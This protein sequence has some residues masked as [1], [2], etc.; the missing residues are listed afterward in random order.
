MCPDID[1]DDEAHARPSCR[2]RDPDRRS[3]ACWAGARDAPG[4]PHRRRRWNE[5]PGRRR[6]KVARRPPWCAARDSSRFRTQ[7]V[8]VRLA[9]VAA[10]ETARAIAHAV[11]G[12][13]RNAR[14]PRSRSRVELRARAAAMLSGAAGVGPQLV[15]DEVQRKARFGDL[16]A[17]E[18]DAAAECHSPALGQPSPAGEAPPPGRAWKRCQ[19]NLRRVRRSVPA[20]A[21][22]KRRTH[23]AMARSGQASASAVTIASTI[24]FAQWL[25]QSVTGAPS[26]TNTTVPGLG[27]HAAGGGT[28]HRSS[29][30]RHR[31]DR[32]APSRRPTACWHARSSRSWCSADPTPSGR[33]SGPIRD[34][35]TRARIT[36]SSRPCPSSSSVAWPFVGPS[37][38]GRDDRAGAPLGGVEHGV[39]RGEEARRA[40]LGRAAL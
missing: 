39:D 2:R 40:E 20:M 28:R 16:D 18:L 30:Y 29:G 38:P 19:M 17:A 4:H 31:S 15:S 3:A 27:E 23:P 8:A 33:P 26:F 9:V 6:A 1:A 7:H 36:M 21:M 34:L 35:V 14:T 12:G 5:R 24:S 37:L 22:R 32:R 10:G 13:V 25:V 11:A